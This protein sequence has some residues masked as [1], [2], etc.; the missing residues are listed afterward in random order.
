MNG[1]ISIP[2]YPQSRANL[3]VAVEGPV[4][5]GLVADGKL[6]PMSRGQRVSKSLWLWPVSAALSPLCPTANAIF[7]ANAV[8]RIRRVLQGIIGAV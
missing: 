5:E 1:A 6:H 8:D 4:L 3:N 7:H 2:A